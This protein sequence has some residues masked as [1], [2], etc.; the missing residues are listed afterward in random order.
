MSQPAGGGVVSNMDVELLSVGDGG[1][2][3]AVRSY[4]LAQLPVG[5]PTAAIELAA[6][7]RTVTLLENYCFFG[8]RYYKLTSTNVGS[9]L[10]SHL[11]ASLR[12]STCTR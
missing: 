8:G 1:A 2:A 12:R 5:A 11:A 9:R 3:V 6:D 4:Q 10:G 7:L